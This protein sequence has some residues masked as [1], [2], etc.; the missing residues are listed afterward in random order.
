MA[1]YQVDTT[2]QVSPVCTDPVQS[3]LASQSPASNVALD[4]ALL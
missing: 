3:Q 4:D 2:S 1:V